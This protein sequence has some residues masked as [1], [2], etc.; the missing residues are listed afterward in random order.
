[1]AVVVLGSINLDLIARVKKVPKAG[2]TGLADSMSTSPGGKGANQALAA[3]RMGAQTALLG[4][5]GEDAFAM[6]ALKFLRQDGVDLSRIGVSPDRPTGLAMIVVEESGQNAITVVPGANAAVGEAVLT[7]LK[8]LL[9][10]QDMLVL[11][12][13]IPLEVV[14]QAI[15]IA[16]KAK[17]RVLLD[18]APAIERLPKAFYRVDILV[19][20]QF[21]A[22]TILGVS[23]DDV[24]SAKAAARQLRARGAEVAIVKL[25]ELGVVWAT[26]RGLFYLPGE[27][28]AAVDAVGAGDAFAGALAARLD[29]KDALADAIVWANRAAALSTTKRGAQP[30][31]PD[32]SQVQTMNQL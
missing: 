30:S 9:S 1:M 32:W 3:Q 14:E 28:V 12:L 8:A 15:Y 23:I 6:Q 25:G 10:A 21:E 18:P 7:D 4:M 17:A 11:Q 2:E 19:P 16:H 29:Q 22:Q 20:N 13:E 31:F 24:R 5:V 26:G 27:I